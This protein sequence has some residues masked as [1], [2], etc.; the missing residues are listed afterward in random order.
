MTLRVVIA[1]DEPVA[2]R[3]LRR[4]LRN[5]T[6]VE[7]AG[8]CGDGR[9]T[10]ECIEVERPD[11]VLL[12]VQMPDVGGFDVVEALGRRLPA[13]VFVTAFDRYAL[14]AFEVHAVDYLLKPVAEARFREAIGRV[15]SR[16]G[17]GDVTAIAVRLE[18]VLKEV[19]S[20][21]RYLSHIPIRSGDR[22]VLV[23]VLEIDWVEAADNYATL[24]ADGRTH[25][26]RETMA[27]LE[28]SLDPRKFV[29]IHRSSIVQL[30]RVRELIPTLHGTLSVVLENGTRLALGRTYR[31][32]LERALGRKL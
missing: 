15:R 22:I 11:L 9:S 19:R 28:R 25:L 23:P 21:S 12:D 26:L 10:I 16:L 13:V 24:H 18:A 30:D 17:H 14:R 7:I 6:D 5:E 4:L 27:T 3:R 20:T 29:R 1:D 8:E 31:D 32:T 2:R